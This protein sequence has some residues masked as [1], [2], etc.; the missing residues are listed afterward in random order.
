MLNS[1]ILLVDQVD[2]GVLE[3][4]AV[5]HLVLE[6]VE[7]KLELPADVMLFAMVVFCC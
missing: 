7:R 2:F 3:V 5:F 1:D 6:L 4:A